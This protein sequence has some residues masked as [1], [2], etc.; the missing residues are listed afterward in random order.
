M[1]DLAEVTWVDLAQHLWCDRHRGLWHGKLC[2]ACVA[3]V[4]PVLLEG[5]FPLHC[6]DNCKDQR[7]LET[8][9]LR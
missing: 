4:K 6:I 5:F 3:W 2:T 1:L 9:T 7:A 8:P